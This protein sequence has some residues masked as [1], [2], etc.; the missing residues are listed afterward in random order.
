MRTPTTTKV[1]V[2]TVSVLALALFTAPVTTS[3]AATHDHLGNDSVRLHAAIGFLNAGGR[4]EWHSNRD[5]RHAAADQELHLVLHGVPKLDGKRLRVRVNGHLV[6][7]D[8]VNDSGRARLHRHDGM[9]TMH[10]GW[11]IRVRTS[12]GALVTSTRFHHD[13]HHGGGGHPH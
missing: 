5:T 4:V 9:H 3:T 10:D 13:D 6:G 7:R 8:Q 2:S 1:A 11:R 12:S